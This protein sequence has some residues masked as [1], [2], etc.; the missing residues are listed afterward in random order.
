[1][2][3]WWQAPGFWRIAAL[4]ALLLSLVT[5]S[6]PLRADPPHGDP[7]WREATIA[8]YIGHLDNLDHLVAACQNQRAALPKAANFPAC[9]PEQI[10]A[11]DRVAWTAGPSSEKREVRYD[12]LRA[13]LTRAAQQ[14]SGEKPGALQILTHEQ[15]KSANVDELLAQSRQRLA[16]D[17]RQ[18]LSAAAPNPGYE[19]EHKT[20]AAI[21]AERAYQQSTKTTARDRF[22]EWLFNLLNRL[23]S[24]IARMGSG[25]PWFVWALRILLLAVI[26]TA[27]AWF[28]VRVEW[29]ARHRL[30]LE[31]V[32]APGAPSAREW[33]LWLQDAQAMAAA[34]RWREA[35]H[36]L[37]WASI[38]RL[39]SMGLWPAD[40]ARTPREY[41]ALIAATDPRRNNLIGLTRAFERFWYGGRN[42]AETD[43]SAA[44]A[45]AAALGVE[46]R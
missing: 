42:A 43:Y 23:F 16:A 30:S 17:N 34:G 26:L 40:R 18:A 28:L 25:A 20:I 19:S 5:A 41:L 31:V 46:I 33:Q 22:A 2:I 15:K 7:G 45:L 3:F 6:R 44:L 36:L 1:M 27:L 39:E 24:G 12:W 38:S 10:G 4:P 35:I 37:Y 13:V 29:N 8:E 9:D 32:P 21:L 14:D 11:N